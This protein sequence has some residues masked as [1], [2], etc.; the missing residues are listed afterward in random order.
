[1]TITVGRGWALTLLAAAAYVPAPLL[2]RP[3]AREASAPSTFIVSCDCATSA[4]RARV[5]RRIERAGGRILYSYATIGGFAV[6]ARRPQDGVALRRRLER[7]A[8]IQSVQP[9]SVIRL[10]PPGAPQ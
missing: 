3:L 7:V 5:Q 1:M 10:A 4:K 8:G 6:T 2:A 9:D